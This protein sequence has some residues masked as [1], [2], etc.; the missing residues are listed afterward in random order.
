MRRRGTSRGTEPPTK[1][2][3]PV[4]LTDVAI[5][6]AKP[7]DKPQKLSDAGGLYIHVTVAGTKSWRVIART[8]SGNQRYSRCR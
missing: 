3:H 2:R 7:A 6:R 4:P 8:A 1:S 5:R